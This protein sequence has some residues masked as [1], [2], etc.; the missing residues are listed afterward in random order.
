MLCGI[1]KIA[2]ISSTHLHIFYE[3][4]NRYKLISYSTGR[5]I[6]EIPEFL[7]LPGTTKEKSTFRAK[8]STSLGS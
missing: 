5:S 6:G 3:F 4:E 7:V 8:A 2:S 1:Y